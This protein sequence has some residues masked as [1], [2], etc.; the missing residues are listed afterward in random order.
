MT[1]AVVVTEEDL[2]EIEDP[3]DE[4]AAAVVAVDQVIKIF[5][6]TKADTFVPVRQAM[7]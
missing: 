2:V 4:E 3:L 1:D 5:I 6:T 7:K